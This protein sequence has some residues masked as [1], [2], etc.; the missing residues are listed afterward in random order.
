MQT[1]TLRVRMLS[2]KRE[3]DELRKPGDFCIRSIPI[4]GD[5]KYGE[6]KGNKIIAIILKCPFCGMDMASTSVHKINY[7]RL[8]RILSFLKMPFGVT[9]KPYLICPYNPTH[10]FS[11]KNGIIKSLK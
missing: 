3:S 7:S 5:D 6:D 10:K 2:E 4:H 9:I 11:I 8:G 1:S